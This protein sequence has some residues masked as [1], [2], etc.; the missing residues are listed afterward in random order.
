M[1]RNAS[2]V[3]LANSNDGSCDL[4]HVQAMV[5]MAGSDHWIER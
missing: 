2:F 4:L 1:T 3:H 5:E